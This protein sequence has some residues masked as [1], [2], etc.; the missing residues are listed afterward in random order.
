[1]RAEAVTNRSGLEGQ[2][3]ASGSVGGTN[4]KRTGSPIQ[5][6]S[7][8]DWEDTVGGIKWIPR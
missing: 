5:C 1:M 4:D 3:G 6:P 7:H 8:A 2:A